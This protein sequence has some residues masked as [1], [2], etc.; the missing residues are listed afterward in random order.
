MGAGQG[1]VLARARPMEP[2][3]MQKQRGHSHQAILGSGHESL[4]TLGQV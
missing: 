3:F 1:R 4:G 2:G